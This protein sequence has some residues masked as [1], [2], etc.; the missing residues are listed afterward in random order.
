MDLLRIEFLKTAAD[1]FIVT[2]KQPLLKFAKQIILM[3]SC[4]PV[5]TSKNFVFSFSP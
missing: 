2:Q 5:L 4:A 3:E 1:L